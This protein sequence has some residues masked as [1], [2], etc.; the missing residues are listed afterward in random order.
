MSDVTVSQSETSESKSVD[1][2]RPMAP[3]TLPLRVLDTDGRRMMPVA[4]SGGYLIQL[5]DI[6]SNPA[7][8]S[9]SHRRVGKVMLS[10]DFDRL[11]PDQKPLIRVKTR[12]VGGKGSLKHDAARITIRNGPYRPP[13]PGPRFT[14][15]REGIGDRKRI[16][17]SSITSRQGYLRKQCSR[18]SPN[19]GRAVL[20]YMTLI[21]QMLDRCPEKSVT[22]SRITAS[23]ESR[24]E[25]ARKTLKFLQDQIETGN[26]SPAQKRSATKEAHRLMDL[27]GITRE[28]PGKGA[29]FS[30][31]GLA[32]SEGKDQ[33]GRKVNTGPEIN[34]AVSAVSG[35]GLGGK[36]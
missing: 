31:V 5:K 24:K 15:V 3:K 20:A 34:L 18:I 10:R 17:T 4:G 2:D 36:D 19:R 22:R 33:Y 30:P 35:T 11:S 9:G 13:L 25:A 6:P 28:I 7:T 8:W 1:S 29:R 32:L 16:D 21:E 12:G 14:E 26:L 23:T 27:I